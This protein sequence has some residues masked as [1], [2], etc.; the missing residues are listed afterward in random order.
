M[1]RIGLFIIFFVS[2]CHQPPVDLLKTIPL[3]S[4][5][6]AVIQ[7]YPL[8]KKPLK[9]K[10]FKDQQLQ[11]LIHIALTDSPDIT[12]VK[13][14]VIRAEQIAQAAYATLWPVA[15]LT[16]NF[17]KRFFK[18]HG[19][20]PQP[21]QSLAFEQL[22]QANIN[23]NFNY[24]L[25]FWG[26]N[27]ENLAS[28]L[29]E[30]CAAK[31]AK[32]HTKLILSSLIAIH[33]FALQNIE[34]Q[35]NLARKVQ[36]AQQE[37]QNIVLSRA[38]KG[39]LSDVPVKTALTQLEQSY[40]K[41]DA[42]KLEKQQVQFKLA[43]LMGKNPLK[44]QIEIK[45]TKPS[46]LRLSLP[47]ILPANLLAQRPDI[48]AARAKAQAAAH[49]VQVAKTAFYPN[50]NLA[51]FIS[52]QSFYFSQFFNVAIRTQGVNAALDLPIFDAGARQANLNKQYAEYELAVNQYNQT[53]LHALHDVADN[54]AAFKT[55]EQ[56]IKHQHRAV[57]ATQANF[58]LLQARFTHGIIDYLPVLE[59]KETLF[60]QQA[61][62]Y[63]LE[64]NKKQT[65]VAL[66]TALGGRF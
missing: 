6:L 63:G 27:R 48:L 66:V 34:L 5:N 11:N 4:K 37:I 21:L 60:E 23:F 32:A 38:Q 20:L 13:I 9:Q 54:L 64:N 15:G 61:V 40:L 16:S 43:Y 59:V 35:I 51:A 29:S 14:R 25:D 53:I 50:I 47:K 45:P 56:K 26:K 19:R 30:I 28:H 36:S 8:P 49:L 65:Y 57:A 3:N 7:H 31:M 2:A 55:I 46:E 44:T 41:L 52:G 1:Y 39:V 58:N 10:L 22:S 33:Y 17:G 18:A 62:L 24:E 42:L 12:A